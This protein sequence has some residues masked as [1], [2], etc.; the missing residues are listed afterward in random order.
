MTITGLKTNSAIEAEIL[1]T[2]S[3]SPYAC[4]AL[5]QLSG[6]FSNF[7]YRGHT[8]NPLPDG[9]TSVCIKHGE[10]YFAEWKH[11]TAS[12]IRCDA[13]QA[14]IQQVTQ[15]HLQRVIYGDVS[16]RVPRLYHYFPQRNIQVGEDV[17]DSKT[18]PDSLQSLSLSSAVSIGQGLGR[19][20]ASFH[21]WARSQAITDLPTVIKD[22]TQ[23]FDMLTGHIYHI[24]SEECKNKEIGQYCK[25]R[26]LEVAEEGVGVVH[27]DFTNRNV[28]IQT[29]HKKDGPHVHLAIVDWEACRYGDQSWDIANFIASVYVPH[30]AYSVEVADPM[31]QAFIQGYGI[32]GDEQ[33]FRVA[34]Q[35]GM[36]IFLW[37]WYAR[38]QLTEEKAEDLIQLARCLLI[39]G[40]ER[41]REWVK[42]SFLGC[43]LDGA[44]AGNE[45]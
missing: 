10:E 14:I 5:K 11:V 27:G 24:I 37:S 45:N 16:V 4:S 15:T 39:K 12:T 41:D 1:E 17:N 23:L 40:C 44:A 7:T 42:H 34:I 21:T 13:E 3:H 2:L 9:S 19:W 38:G 35:T 36:Y 31:L 8:L 43:L 32:L 30:R 28:L 22:N 26:L 29:S 18:L 6:G 20:L 33:V 25:D